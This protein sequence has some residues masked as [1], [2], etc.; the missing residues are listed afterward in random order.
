MPERSS[1]TATRRITPVELASTEQAEPTG[2]NVGALVVVYGARPDVGVT[3]VAEALSLAFRAVMAEDVALAE[4][5]PRGDRVHSH[6]AMSVAIHIPGADSAMVRR[7]DGVWTFAMTRPLA[8]AVGDAKAV[9]TALDAMR[10]RFSVSVAELE[11]HVNERTLTAFDAADRIVLLTEGSVPS[12]RGTQRALRLCQR[13]NYPDEK[14][15][16]VL[17]R[18]DAPGSLPP[19]DVS[20][21][22]RRELFWLVPASAPVDVAGLAAKLLER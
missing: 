2:E 4:L 16:V 17:N 20:A 22:L 10:A 18:F 19:A 1:P 15:C 6:D 13:L 12:V 14:M 5:D 21:A 9:M 7:T 8:P 3:T 11:H